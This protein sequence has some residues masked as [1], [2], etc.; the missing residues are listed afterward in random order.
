M[1]HE[2]E[3]LFNVELRY[4]N[5]LV[6]FP[7]YED[8]VSTIKDPLIQFLDG[9]YELSVLDLSN[10]NVQI[11]DISFKNYYD[12][13]F[14]TI[15]EFDSIFSFYFKPLTDFVAPF[16]CLEEGL[17]YDEDN[18]AIQF[19]PLGKT[20]I[21]DYRTMLQNLYKTHD[22]IDTQIKSTKITT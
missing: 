18:F 10:H 16:Q 4:Q 14:P 5:G 15:Q 19:D 2:K 7:S 21:D 11:D 3:F 6:I 22:M 9:I 20:S 8:F 13:R 12:S 1:F 17:T